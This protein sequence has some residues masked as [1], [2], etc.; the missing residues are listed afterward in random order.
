MFG[1]DTTE[2][3][4]SLAIAIIYPFFFSKLANLLVDHDKITG[5]CDGKYPSYIYPFYLESKSISKMDDAENERKKAE[6]E[7]CQKERTAKLDDA[8]FK[9][10]MILIIIAFIGILGSSA[11][12]THSTKVGV[13]L[14]G[15]FTLIIALV[16][17][18]HKYNENVKLLILGLSLALL[19]FLS[20]KLYSLKNVADLFSLVE[21]GTK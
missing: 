21:F 6:Y 17:Y 12:Q 16:G 5:M 18:W 10:H 20:I 19:M 7:E 9:N 11:I 8:N 4:F 15:I 2:T 1:L 3:I 13:G 14:G